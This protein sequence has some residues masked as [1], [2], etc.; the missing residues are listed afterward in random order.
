MKKIGIIFFLIMFTFGFSSLQAEGIPVNT[1]APDFALTDTH[2]TKH[3]LAGYKG[4]FVVLEWTNPGCPFVRKHYGSG[5]MQALQ[6]KYTG[7]GVLWLSVNSSAQG[8]EGCFEN[9]PAATAWLAEQKASPT[10]LIR[11]EE[12]KLGRAVYRYTVQ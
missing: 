1:K 4:K 12:G 11:D 2:G 7:L 3:S 6:K 9:D 10:S 8:K 5:N